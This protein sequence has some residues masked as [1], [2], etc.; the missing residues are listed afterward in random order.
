MNKLER[1]FWN[2]E[3]FVVLLILGTAVGALLAACYYT[4]RASCEN[5]AELTGEQHVYQFSG[6]RIKRDGRWV[7]LEAAESGARDLTIREAK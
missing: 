6:C 3:I 4:S 5:Y 1:F 7:S 2:N